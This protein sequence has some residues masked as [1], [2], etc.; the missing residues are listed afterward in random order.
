MAQGPRHDE[1]R[2]GRA[3]RK[4]AARSVHGAWEPASDRPDPIAVLERQNRDRIADLVPV[5]MGRMLESP[6]A[7]LRGAAAVMAG[8]LAA[9]AVSGIIVQI[10][11]DAH[12]ANFG[13]AAS[14]ERRLLFDV[15]DFDETCTGPF[16]WDLKRLAT[17]AVVAARG[18]LLGEKRGVEAALAGVRSYRRHLRHYAQ[19]GVLDVWYSRVD[20][21][22]AAATLGAQAPSSL[23]SVVARARRHTSSAALP[24]LTA[25]A[26]DG[27]RHI[28]DHPPLVT[29]DIGP[30]EPDGLDGLFS[31][32]RRSLEDDHLALLE[33]FTLV[34]VARKVV[35]VG[36]VGTRCFIALLTSD[37]G[38]PLFL[39]VK[40]AGPSVYDS[41]QRRGAA[42][43][44][45]SPE[46]FTDGPVP[47]PSQGQR[48]I[49]G[50]RLMQ[51][52]S[53]IFLGAASCGG[54][55][56]YVRQLRDMKGTVD[57]ATLDPAAFVS[58]LELCGWTL[59]RAHARSGPAAAIDGY[60]GGGAT[61][62]D[63]ITRFAVSYAD[64]TE[65]DHALL[66]DAVASGRIEATPGV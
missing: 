49:D 10:C 25:L 58:Y 21:D 52:A 46:L 3:R 64:Q 13:V 30:D 26:G 29:H 38:E 43:P 47:E 42:V 28:I 40:E 11:G 65:R 18:G 66:V 12:V 20:A 56:Y 2:A 51:A 36:S 24:R 1:R 7:F 50:Q 9:T 32:Y 5:R 60:L 63:A 34:D 39:Q 48:V 59:A 45:H 14:P 8:D 53:D 4:V 6:F 62:D 55:D 33:R 37:V 16:E 35:G 31:S 61:F 44:V 17:S 15:N 54:R 19:L 57:A 22:E 27:A 41:V 23:T